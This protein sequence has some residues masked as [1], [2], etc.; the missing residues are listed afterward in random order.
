MSY[1]VAKRVVAER[2]GLDRKVQGDMLGSFV[3]DGLTQEE[4]ETESLLQMYWL[5]STIVHIK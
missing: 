5:P 3:R 2:Y 4:A 1:R